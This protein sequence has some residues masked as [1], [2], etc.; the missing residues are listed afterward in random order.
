MYDAWMSY[1]IEQG[2]RIW[3]TGITAVASRSMSDYVG[4][5]FFDPPYIVV[6]ST[7]KDRC[8]QI[9]ILYN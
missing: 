8:L 2:I 3:K 7:L 6:G 4:D 1:A 5:L 9:P